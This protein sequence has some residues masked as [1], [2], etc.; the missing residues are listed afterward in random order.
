MNALRSTL[1]ATTLL[2]IASPIDFSRAEDIHIYAADNGAANNPN[3]LII[4]DNSANWS[5]AS[6]HWPGGIKQGEAELASLKT[7]ISELDA[8]VNVGLM[9]FTPGSGQAKDGGYIRYAM[10]AMNATNKAAFQEMVGS[11]TCATGVNSLNGVPNCILKNFDAPAEKVGTA[12]TDYSAAMFEAFKYFGGYTSPAH[13]TDD[14]AGSPLDASHFGALRYAGNPEV[15][16]DR[17]AYSG[18]ASLP[19]YV[20][21]LSSANSCAKNYII[22]IGNGYPVQDASPSLLTGVGGN[23]TQIAVPDF[24]TVAGTTQTLLGSGV[25]ASQA[26]CE[27]AAASTYG[28]SYNSYTCS[29]ASATSTSNETAL[30]TSACGTYGSVAACQT[31][32]ATLYPG[33]AAYT[34]TARATV[35]NASTSLGES[36]CGQYASVAACQAGAAAA[37]PGYATYSCTPSACSTN[38]QTLGTTSCGQYSNVVACEAGAPAAFPGYARY[39][40]TSAGSCSTTL[41]GACYNNVSSCQAAGATGYDSVSCTPGTSCG[42]T[43]VIQCG[44][45]ADYNNANKCEPGGLGLLGSYASY[46]CVRGNKNSEGC[47]SNTY[48]WTITGYGA[49]YTRTGSGTRYTVQ[50]TAPAG[51]S[52]SMS[53]TGGGSSYD[54]TGTTTTT[55]VTYSIFGNK[56]VTTAV[57]TG[58]FSGTVGNYADEWARFLYSTDVSAASGQQNVKTF[59]IDVFKDHQEADQTKLLMSMA[60][61]GAGKYFSATDGDSITNALRQIFAEIQ[62]VNSV[63]SSSS[64]PVNVNTQGTYLNQVFI[65]MFRPDGGAKPRWPGNL[66][67]YQFKINGTTGELQLADQNNN[68]AISSTTGFIT[69]CAASIWTTDSGNYWNYG[70]SNAQGSCTAVSS[71]F[72]SSGSSSAYSDSPDGDIVEKGGAAQQLR[73]VRSSAGALTSSS[74]RYAA[75]A[76]GSTPANSACRQLYTAAACSAGSCGAGLTTFSAAN[77]ALT[78]TAFGVATD[79][80]KNTLINWI[81]GQDIDDENGNGLITEVRPSAHG[82]VVHS[83]PAIIDFGGTTGVIAFYGA[84]DGFLHAVAGDKGDTDGIELWGFVAPDTYPR[85]NRLRTN[86][87]LINFPGVSATGATSKDYFFDGSIATHQKGGTVWIFPTMRRGGRAIYA[88]DVSTPTAPT[89]KWRKGCFTS[90]TTD[91]SNCSSG[92]SSIGQ[93]WSKPQLG[94]LQGYVDGSGNPKPVLVFGGGYDTCEDANSQTRCTATP[95]KGAKIWFVDADTGTILRSYPTNYSVAGE[96]TLL[97]DAGGKLTRAYAADTGGYVYRIEIGTYD[98]T[99]FSAWSANSLASTTTIAALSETGHARKFL[100]GP[101]VAILPDYNAVML[102]SGDR[103]HPLIDSYACNNF[104]TTAGNYVANEFFMIKDTRASTYP[105]AP[106]TPADLTDVTTNTTATVASI[107]DAGWHFRLTGGACEQVVNKAISAAGLVFFGTNQPIDGSSSA[108]CVSNLGTA[109]GYAVDIQT[110]APNCADC[111]RSVA[112]IGGGLPPSPVVGVVAVEGTKLPFIIG[113]TLPPA[114]GGACTGDGCSSLGG[115]KL[116][117]NPSSPRFRIYWKMPAD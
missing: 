113:G 9:M 89:L 107:A 110:A 25:Y 8:S 56:N 60:R 42:G 1:L 66:K 100:Y 17:A 30:G 82:G 111:N 5:A 16:S 20:S 90:S 115:G 105:L 70:G 13:A 19:N 87:P 7:V 117:I 64:L 69:P 22:F 68:A 74:Q 58:T 39:S 76:T 37:F 15:N 85:F 3:V 47:T 40:C 28:S 32:A 35:C 34:C 95:R 45:N 46:T 71:S 96:V 21:P 6:Q 31:A 27:T 65:G 77:A 44:G 11:A 114:G 10:R 83:Q 33:Y 99:T 101:D 52:Y 98:G 67:Q 59:T 2:A 24:T 51:N 29:V 112:Y 14:V 48:P 97:K 103:E 93:T 63:F 79:A 108:S 26:A 81:R 72:P 23:G 61:V 80:E 78:A 94:Y 92:W 50:G 49:N 84:D 43:S 55:T 91:D 75:C 41:P 86:T 106:T 4:L 104:S 102:G 36:S 57:P 73:G 38:P 18:G 12:K 116:T 53:A 54:I 88:F 109:R 62:S